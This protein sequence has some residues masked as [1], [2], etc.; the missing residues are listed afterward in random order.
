MCAFGEME[1][2]R[3][4]ALITHKEPSVRNG[5]QAVPL[6]RKSRRWRDGAGLRE[7][8][9]SSLP[10]ADDG[11]DGKLAQQGADLAGTGKPFDHGPREA[12]KIESLP[13]DFHGATGSPALA[14]QSR[15][16]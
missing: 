11:G 15:R 14:A 13:L 12:T 1:S 3:S 2:S 4:G 10:G 9:L 6:A 16:R 5:R 7:R 8:R